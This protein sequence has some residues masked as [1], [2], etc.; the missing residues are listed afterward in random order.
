METLDTD[1]DFGA[2]KRAGGWPGSGPAATVLE[3]ARH[4]H[5]VVLSGG[6]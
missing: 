6:N 3:L 2:P 5:M 4:A 1:P